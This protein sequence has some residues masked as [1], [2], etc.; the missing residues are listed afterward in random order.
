MDTQRLNRIIKLTFRKLGLELQRFDTANTDESILIRMFE[1]LRPRVLL[2]V[3]ANVGQYALQARELGYEHLIVSFEALPDAH[4]K[5]KENARGDDKWVI[6]PCA[7]LGG[8]AGTASI[9][10]AGN[11]QSSSLLPMRAE[12]VNAAPDSRYVGTVQVDVRRLDEQCETLVPGNTPVFL[13]IDTQGY[14]REV[15][16][17]ATRLLPRVAGLQLELSLVPLY[18]GCPMMM[19]MVT[20]VQQ[21][22]FELFNL[23]PTFK[24]P[25]TGRLLQADGFFVRRSSVPD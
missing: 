25:R 18:D 2:D 11:S 6:A 5:L 17:G 20:Y 3:G 19:D 22:G 21:L 14:E 10:V 23:S 13:K 7:A 16:K 24:D 15:L 12:H 9:N 8:S 4:A 1:L